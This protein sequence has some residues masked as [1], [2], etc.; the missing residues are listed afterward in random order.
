[1]QNS[2]RILVAIG[3]GATRVDGVRFG[4]RCRL[5]DH[6]GGGVQSTGSMELRRR[7]QNAAR[8]C[9]LEG[10]FRTLIPI[11]GRTIADQS[12][13]SESWGSRFDPKVYMPHRRSSRAG[14]TEVR[15]QVGFPHAP[16]RAPGFRLHDHKNTRTAAGARVRG[17]SRW[18]YR[19]YLRLSGWSDGRDD[20]TWSAGVY[21]DVF[22]A[23][24]G[25][26]P[27]KRSRSMRWSTATHRGVAY[28][29]RG[30]W[31]GGSWALRI[32]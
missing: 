29:A 27:C 4:A 26:G 18:K 1:M 12:G 7:W 21:F 23:R 24:R 11:S 14:S 2:G 15:R 9:E 10:G 17:P 25:R 19:M 6:D 28:D 3:G 16:R 13:V 32:N 20:N 30:D 8:I 22:R 5:R 31:R